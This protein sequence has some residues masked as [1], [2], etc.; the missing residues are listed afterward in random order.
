MLYYPDPFYLGWYIRRYIDEEIPSSVLIYHEGDEDKKEAIGMKGN[1]ETKATPIPLVDFF[2]LFSSEPDYS[3]ALYFVADKEE[4]SKLPA[5]NDGWYIKH[6]T[7]EGSNMRELIATI[8][9][10]THH[11]T[12]RSLAHRDG[13][14]NEK[15]PVNPT[16]T[17]AIIR[18]QNIRQPQLRTP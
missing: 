9:D 17:P 4:A 10:P 15:R 14:W 7:S 11:C 8:Y 18:P 2:E 1:G 3:N 5:G 13:P 12:E 16:T 6:P